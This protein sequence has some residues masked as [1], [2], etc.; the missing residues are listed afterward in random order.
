M[1]SVLN[2]SILARR[3]DTL[4]QNNTTSTIYVSGLG[5]NVSSA[6]VKERRGK[7]KFIGCKV[8]L[9]LVDV[10]KAEGDSEFIQ[11][12]Y[13]TFHCLSK[14]QYKNG[15]IFGKYCKNRF[16]PTCLGIRKA[17]LIHKY[18][19]ILKDWEKPYFV[20][21]T[22]KACNAEDLE[23]TIELQKKAFDRIIVRNRTKVNRGKGRLIK[24]LRCHE[25]NFNPEACTYN[26][27]FHLIV[28]DYKT[29][30]YLVYEWQTTINKICGYQIANNAGQDFRKIINLE[31][32][33]IE[34]I[35]YG[36]K[37]FT[38]KSVTSEIANNSVLYARAFYNILKAFE[39]KRLLSTYGFKLPQ[40]AKTSAKIITQLNNPSA[41]VY[42]YKV[43]DWVNPETGSMLTQ[44][45]PPQELLELINSI[46][47]ELK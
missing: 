47:K 33:L 21:L 11:K 5:S 40:E 25:C 10:A 44:Y 20:T 2:S 14:V 26:P 8:A 16:C 23:K 17:D 46:D 9:A 45:Y 27:H 24:C 4:A 7:T 3:L 39:N 32:Q 19:P 29:A 22:V 35:K 30:H 18:E 43:H 31:T 34:T 42:H 37:I 1:S 15:I 12:A 41:L 6:E 28:P 36:A 13:N 38:E